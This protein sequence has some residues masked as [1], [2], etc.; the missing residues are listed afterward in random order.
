MEHWQ[1]FFSLPRLAQKK[2]VH[3]IA[4][5]QTLLLVRENQLLFLCGEP[6]LADALKESG[7]FILIETIVAIGIHWH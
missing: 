5:A 4:P 1:G 6:W 7:Q 3:E 2:T